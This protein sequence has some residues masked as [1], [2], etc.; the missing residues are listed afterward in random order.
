[1]TI[2]ENSLLQRVARLEKLLNRK[3]EDDSA[4][5]DQQSEVSATNQDALSAV[6][7]TGEVRAI[8]TVW[9]YLLN[10]GP[11]SIM[12]LNKAMGW[13]CGT[14]LKKLV[15]HGAVIRLTGKSYKANPDYKFRDVDKIKIINTVY[16]K[17]LIS[18]NFDKFRSLVKEFCDANHLILDRC[19]MYKDLVTVDLLDEYNPYSSESTQKDKSILTVGFDTAT[20]AFVCQKIELYRSYRQVYDYG[21]GS[22]RRTGRSSWEQDY[23]FE[24]TNQTRCNLAFRTEIFGRSHTS[25]EE[26]NKE[27]FRLFGI[28]EK[29]KLRGITSIVFS[30]TEYKDWDD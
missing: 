5:V 19:V 25:I 10:N 18:E 8:Y 21:F 3:Y 27:F 22:S 1:M 9:E 20:Q 17:D 15:E 14:E 16:T 2:H 26:F 7:S 6:W 24:N 13:P 30:L 11:K 4:D 28:G 12:A 29:T 23:S